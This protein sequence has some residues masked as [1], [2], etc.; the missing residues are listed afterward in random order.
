MTEREEKDGVW[1]E[2]KKVF[3]VF[4]L[5]YFLWQKEE[6]QDAKERQKKF[7]KEKYGLKNIRGK[8]SKR[9]I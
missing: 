1:D 9:H 5:L 7:E 2:K 3:G 8:T 6:D 4:I